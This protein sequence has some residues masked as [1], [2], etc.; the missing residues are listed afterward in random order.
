MRNNLRFAAGC[1]ALL[2]LIA[3]GIL[4]APSSVGQTQTETSTPAFEAASVKPHQDTG[5]RD[6]TRSIEPGRITVV[7][8][9][10][11]EFIGFAYGV[12]GYQISGPDWIVKPSSSVTYD[13]VAT[14]GKAVSVAEIKRMLQ[15]LLAERFQ[16]VFHRETRELPVFALLVAKDGPKF[17]EPGN[18][19]ASVRPDGD[20]GLIFTNYSMDRLAEWLTGLPSMGRPVIDHTDLAGSFSF[21]ANLFELGKGSS[22]A[23][24]KG[25]IASD[26]AVD[27]LRAM[28]PDQLGLKLEA[29]R[30]PLEILVIDRAEKVPTD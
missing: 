11:G 18:G 10:L 29:Q 26:A 19:E 22:P 12:K 15:T 5:R 21:R 13:V 20:G 14:A 24:L 6:R 28:L 7:D 17:K 30:A 23:E 8:A 16:L 1:L 3:V 25:A 2:G 27:T 4:G 9:P